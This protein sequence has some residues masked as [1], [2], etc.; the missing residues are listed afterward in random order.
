MR[1]VQNFT[2]P[3]FQ[4]KTFTPSI[5]PN[6]N[7]FNDKNT[8]N[9]WKWRNLHRWQKVY[10]AT[11]SDG[12]EKSRLRIGKATITSISIRIKTDINSIQVSKNHLIGSKTRCERWAEVNK[13]DFRWQWHWST[14]LLF[15]SWMSPLWVG[16]CEEVFRETTTNKTSSK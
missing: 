6:F 2:L 16:C 5:S 15:S 11:G 13:G 9:E 12:R 10:T 4:A 8:N 14:N 7:S 3:D 1:F